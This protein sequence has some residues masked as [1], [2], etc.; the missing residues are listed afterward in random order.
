MSENGIILKG[1]GGFYYVDTAAGLVECKAR[2][3]FRI[4]GGKPVIGDRVTIQ[5]NEDGTGYILSMEPRKTELLRPAVANIDQLLIVCSA[6]A[7]KTEPFL[8]DKITSIAS[9]KNMDT[10]IVINKTDLDRGDHLA[11]IYTKAGFPVYRVSAETGEGTEALRDCLR[12]RISA[13]AGNSGVGKSS[14]LNR[15]YPQFHAQVGAISEKIERGRHTTRHVELMKLP[16]GG[17]L[18]DT[19]G[20]S[21]FQA[22]KMD[23]V[24]AADLQDTFREFEPYLGRCR[25]T[26]CA[27]V[28]E[29]GCAVRAAVEAGE[30]P[31]ER[32]ESYCRLYESVKDIKEWSLNK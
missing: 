12:G 19:P 6:A 22:E 10:V 14:L 4:Q 11:A 28:K 21:A 2:G 24:L 20:F 9:R 31:K 27:H 3:K 5:L 7:P 32:H 18:A 16:E 1:I 29:K 13:F 8:I 25:F 23:L 26:G 17:Y 30:I 15:L